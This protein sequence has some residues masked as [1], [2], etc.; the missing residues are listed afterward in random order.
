LVTFSAIGGSIGSVVL[1]NSG[2]TAF[3]YGIPEDPVLD[4]PPPPSPPTA[5]EPPMVVEPPTVVEPPEIPLPGALPLF[6]GGL[7]VLGLFGKRRHK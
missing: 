6:L 7:A 2:P 3:N 4:L 5:V 1:S